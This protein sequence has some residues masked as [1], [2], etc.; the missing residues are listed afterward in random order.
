LSRARLLK[1]MVFCCARITRRREDDVASVDVGPGSSVR[2]GHQAPGGRDSLP[3]SPSLIGTWWLWLGSPVGCCE[4]TTV[5]W[6]LNPSSMAHFKGKLCIFNERKEKQLL[7]G[8]CHRRLLLSEYSV[9]WSTRPDWLARYSECLVS[10]ARMA[11][12]KLVEQ[13]SADFPKLVD[14]QVRWD[15]RFGQATSIATG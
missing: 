2:G 6:D 13:C 1:S 12:P 7:E 11:R 14:R 10:K 15:V 5:R 3:P 4:D 8:P 9:C